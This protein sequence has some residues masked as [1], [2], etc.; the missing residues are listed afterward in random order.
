MGK[1]VSKIFQIILDVMMGLAIYYIIS[2]FASNWSQSAAILVTLS[3][4][5][6]LAETVEVNF[7]K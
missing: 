6:V 3:V 1:V 4:T 5:A 7:K 2:T